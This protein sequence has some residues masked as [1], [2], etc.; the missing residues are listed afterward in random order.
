MRLNPDALLHLRVSV[1]REWSQRRTERAGEMKLTSTGI[2][3]PLAR[4]ALDSGY[5]WVTTPD[6]PVFEDLVWPEGARRAW[7]EWAA[8]HE[9]GEPELSLAASV[10]LW[11]MVQGALLFHPVPSTK[12]GPFTVQPTHDMASINWSTDALHLGRQTGAYKLLLTRVRGDRVPLVRR[13]YQ[14]AG[15]TP[16]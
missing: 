12:A 13:Y 11:L 4:N 16:R 7:A 6:V 2:L 8:E 15:D 5:H 10:S 3:H 9:M 14:L 1:P